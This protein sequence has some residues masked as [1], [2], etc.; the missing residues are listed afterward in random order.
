DFPYPNFTGPANAMGLLLARAAVRIRAEGGGFTR[1]NLHRHYLQPLQGTHYWKDVEFL[2]RWPGY[3]KK[4]KTFFGRNLDLALGSAYVWT[5]PARR[6]PA[7][8]FGW[9]RLL[10]GVAGPAE[11]PELRGELRDLSRAL[12]LRSVLPRPAFWRMLLDGTV[13]ACRDLFRRPRAN[14]PAAGQVRL[15]YA[16]AGGAEPVGR[17]PPL[18]RRWFRRFAPVL[19][20][21]ARVVYRNDRTPLGEKLPAAVGLLVRQINVL[22]L[23]NA[24]LLSLAAGVSGALLVGWDRLRGLFGRRPRQTGSEKG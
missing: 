21:A 15:H 14:V 13:N 3:V 17:P 6:L 23:L 1:A 8:W 20:S 22:D 9:L 5:R 2:R 24:A 10:L 11:M 18:L 4:T 16:V 7:R 19:A 12:R